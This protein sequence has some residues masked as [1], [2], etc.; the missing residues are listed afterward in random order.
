MP[1][2]KLQRF[3]EISN[4]DH[5]FEYTDYQVEGRHKPKGSWNTDIF[6][7]S[8]PIAL[9]LGCGKATTTTSL[10]SMEPDCNFIGIDIKGARIWKGAKR[11]QREKLDNVRFLRMFIEHLDEYFA[12]NEVSAIWITFPDPYPRAGDRDKRLTSP[13]FLKMYKQI[14]KPGSHIYF[15]TDDKNLYDYTVKTVRSF[16][17]NILTQTEN[18]HQTESDIKRKITIKTSFERKHLANQ[19]TIKYGKFSLK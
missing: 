15:K 10:A 11:S 7:N 2:N 19:K 1:V 4:M 9:E 12:P 5:V 18:L 6:G 14:L 8:N 17:G 3:E 16:G 13:R